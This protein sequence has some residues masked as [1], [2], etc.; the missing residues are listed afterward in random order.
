M[1]RL[2]AQQTLTIFQKRL[3]GKIE[4]GAAGVSLRTYAPSNAAV[5]GLDEHAA[6]AIGALSPL[7]A[8]QSKAFADGRLREFALGRLIARRC[9]KDVSVG[10]S[11]RAEIGIG[12]DRGPQW[13]EGVVGSI[14]HCPVAFAAIVGRDAALAGVGIDVEAQQKIDPG[15]VEAVL[16]SDESHDDALVKFSAKESLYK[17][18][19]PIMGQ[20]LDFSEASVRLVESSEQP[21]GHRA[22]DIEY[23]LHRGQPTP[24]VFSRV[25][26]L[27]LAG[28]DL[29]ATAAWISA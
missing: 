10:A 19:A 1:I 27:W 23:T 26:G 8:E 2:G 16:R 5:G 4:C 24:E 3:L 6:E 18:W 25:E 7:E 28:P 12:P 17:L 14:S 11:V 9:L 20:W 22:G 15:I 29:V 21:S 13:P